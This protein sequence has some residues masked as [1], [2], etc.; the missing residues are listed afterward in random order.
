MMIEYLLFNHA[1]KKSILVCIKKPC[2]YKKDTMHLVFDMYHLI[3]KANRNVNPWGPVQGTCHLKITKLSTL[4]SHR[5][6]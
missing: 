3:D 1:I 2:C 6:S 5:D 4:V